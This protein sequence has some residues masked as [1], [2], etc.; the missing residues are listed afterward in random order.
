MPSV[1]ARPAHPWWDRPYWDG[2]GVLPSPACDLPVQW[3]VD[4]YAYCPEYDNADKLAD[5]ARSSVIG[6]HNPMAASGWPSDEGLIL[7]DREVERLARKQDSRERLTGPRPGKRRGYPE[8]FRE[9]ARS[10]Y[11]P[12]E[13][14]HAKVAEALGVSV[15]TVRSWVGPA[16]ARRPPSKPPATVSEP[17]VHEHI[18]ET[19]L[20]A[21]GRSELG[22]RLGYSH[23]YRVAAC[24]APQVWA[25]GGGAFNIPLRTAVR[26]LQDAQRKQGEYFDLHRWEGAT[27][28]TDDIGTE[29]VIE[30][31]E[32]LEEHDFV[33][34]SPDGLWPVFPHS[35][36]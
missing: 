5:R 10:L 33:L 4:D 27:E 13:F 32:L 12:R 18:S 31:I 7:L 2:I 11:K 22:V 23:V 20:K 35:N 19:W 28:I 16:Y 1:E 26:W 25:N 34:S 8:S 21:I 24:L 17:V 9:R 3:R 30:A 14:G 36:P 15:K 29:L 6:A